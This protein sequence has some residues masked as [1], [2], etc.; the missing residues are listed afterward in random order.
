MCTG[1]CMSGR[2]VEGRE[3]VIGSF[4]DDGCTPSVLSGARGW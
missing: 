1:F 4:P 2:G 3:G